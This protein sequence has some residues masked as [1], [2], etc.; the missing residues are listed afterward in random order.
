MLIRNFTL[1]KPNLTS[2]SNISSAW[3]L[4]VHHSAQLKVAVLSLKT[5]KAVC[6]Y[7]W[8][9]SLCCVLTYLFSYLSSWILRFQEGTTTCA[10]APGEWAGTW[11]TVCVY[12]WIEAELIKFH[13]H[14]GQE[15]D[16]SY[17]N[18]SNLLITSSSF[19]WFGIKSSGHSD[20]FLLSTSSFSSIPSHPPS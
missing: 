14:T 3:R 13:L 4:S 1:D 12:W 10:P 6:S 19:L 5:P 11:E 20:F 2:G 16:L 7:S 18:I 8:N 9:D 15:E 17:W